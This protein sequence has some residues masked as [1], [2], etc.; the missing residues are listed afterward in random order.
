M[1]YRPFDGLRVGDSVEYRPSPRATWARGRVVA[2]GPYKMTVESR[3]TKHVVDIERWGGRVRRA[4]VLGAAE[5]DL[6]EHAIK[7]AP[8]LDQVNEL[9]RAARESIALHERVRELEAVITGYE[10]RVPGLERDLRAE[11]EQ[12]T[13]AEDERDR[14]REALSKIKNAF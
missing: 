2:V 13:H 8:T 6:M 7:T 9:V 12:R 11:R 10:A 4:P 1:K 14:A 5:L 3:G